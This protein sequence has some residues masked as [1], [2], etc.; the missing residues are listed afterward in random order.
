M[1]LAEPIYDKTVFPDPRRQSGEIAI[2]ADQA[3]A[4]EASGMQQIHRVDDQ[5]AITGILSNGVP[6]LLNGMNGVLGELYLPAT[7]V[8]R[9]EVTRCVAP[10]R[11]RDA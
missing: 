8:W 3:E 9:G 10:S 5:G 6:V 1:L 4:L 11:A 2:A 7:E